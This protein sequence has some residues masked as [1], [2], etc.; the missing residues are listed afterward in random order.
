MSGAIPENPPPGRVTRLLGLAAGVMSARDALTTARDA[1]RSA[2]TVSPALRALADAVDG[3]ARGLAEFLSGVYRLVE[4]AEDSWDDLDGPDPLPEP[5]RSRLRASL[6]RA[7]DNAFA[8]L[9]RLSGSPV[10]PTSGPG[11][12]TRAVAAAWGGGRAGR[13]VLHCRAHEHR[14]PPGTGAGGA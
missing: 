2:P 10:S 14:G 12:D 9:A 5:E 13:G 6:D 11:I 7:V 4:L 3:E 8:D 1:L